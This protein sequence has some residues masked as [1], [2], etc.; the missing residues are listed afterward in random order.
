MKKRDQFSFFQEFRVRY[1]EIDSQGVVFNSHYM[2]YFDSA[3]TEYIRS[4]N[5]SYVQ[6]VQ[7]RGI[8]FHLV[9]TIIE[10]HKPIFFDEVI[11]VGVA[12]S[13]IGN[14]SLTWSLAIFK[15]DND[16]CLT[17]GEL[18]W[19]CTL[20]GTNKSYPLPEGLVE[21]LKKES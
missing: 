4:L 15:K 21:L 11:E 7:E 6:L 10:F 13:K 18:I 9:K 5:Y 12:L 14:T 2:T 8:D 3:I 20:L 1:S 17:S 16:Q 19:V